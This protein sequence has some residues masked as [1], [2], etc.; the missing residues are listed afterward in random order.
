MSS[1]NTAFFNFKAIRFFFIFSISCIFSLRSSA[2]DSVEYN[3]YPHDS[4]VAANPEH[5]E[6]AEHGKEPFQV[7]KVI[8]EHISDAYE[9]HILSA[10]H[11]HVS[12]PLPMILYS[13]TRGL[14][15]FMSSKFKDE[16]HN[17]VEYNGYKLD[18]HGKVMSTDPDEKI[19]DFS[20]TKNV[21][22]MLFI[23]VILILVFTSV[24]RAYTRNGTAA[25]RG[26]Q[27][28]FE[29]LIVFVRDDVVKPSLGKKT[30]KFLPYLLT[31]FFFIWF[32]NMMGLVPG[33]A[34]VTGNIA[35]TMVLALL[36]MIITNVNG[37]KHYWGHIFWMPGVPTW[38]KLSIMP[39]VEVLSI[40]TKPFALMIRLFANITAGH[41]IILSIVSLIF[42]FGEQSKGAGFGVS[43]ISTAFGVFLFF[44]EL[45][46]AFI[47]AY[48]FTMLTSL[49]IGQAVEEHEEHH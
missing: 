26:M 17:L 35:V 10:G 22:Q 19:Y 49:F 9:W 46:V 45:L 16:H 41:I 38:L 40:F 36:T 13:S 21:A 25:P 18:E 8:M 23:S 47:Q 4:I 44:L 11:T 20:I 2:S 7:D 1:E 5:H 34:N 15:V 33:S 37:N 30:G 3:T 27:T 39:L 12:L 48:I 42:M 14:Q 6:T 32:L 29:L 24:A 43:V 31:L 28:F